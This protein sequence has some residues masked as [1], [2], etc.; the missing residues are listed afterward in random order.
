MKTKG[1]T[2]VVLGSGCF[3]ASS[4]GPVRNPAGYALSR[5]DQTLLFDF[6]FGNLRQL[7]RAQMSPDTVSHAFF[8]HRHPDHVGDLAALLFYYRYDGKPR[9]NKLQIYGPRGF[10]AFFQRLT[11][12]HQPWLRPRGF[13]IEVTELEE[14]AVVRGDGW[15]VVCREVPHST[16]ALA[17]RYESKFGSVCY[18]GDT[19]YDPGIASFAQETDLFVVECTVADG[20]R[21][22][23][24]L[25]V[26][27][28]L[29]L[30]RLSKA[31]KTLLT[32]LSEES[33]KGL[34]RRIAKLP[35][36]YKAKDLLKI[37]IGY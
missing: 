25:R 28:A 12:A 26:S 13:K 19:T 7:A 8:S 4:T 15:R 2:F 11:K 31:K 27:E 20:S 3:T 32:H 33:E 22:D 18:T 21:T 23:G 9:R 34:A 36:V 6:G 29:E 5:G 10:K 14:K 30:A 1:F 37:N 17:F 24:H 16:E 35:R